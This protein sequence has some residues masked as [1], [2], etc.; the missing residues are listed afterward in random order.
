VISTQRDFS[1]TVLDLL[2]GY[3]PSLAGESLLKKDRLAPPSEFYYN[4]KLISINTQRIVSYDLSS[5]QNTCYDFTSP[6]FSEIV[7]GDPE[8]QVA[9]E[10]KAFTRMSQSLLLHGKTK[11]LMSFDKIFNVK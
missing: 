4:S 9:S 1:P 7:C 3:L 10:M 8:A 11:D 6:Q 5:G 2:G